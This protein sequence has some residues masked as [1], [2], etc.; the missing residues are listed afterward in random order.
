[1]L[2]SLTTS[3]VLNEPRMQHITVNDHKEEV[4]SNAATEENGIKILQTQAVEDI[5]TVQHSECTIS[6]VH[7]ADSAKSEQYR[8]T[9][10][11]SLQ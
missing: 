6:K 5:V 2:V 1:M 11:P 7:V 3:N 8:G 9:F 10:D 4:L